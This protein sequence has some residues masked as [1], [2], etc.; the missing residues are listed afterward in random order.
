MDG[1]NPDGGVVAVKQAAPVCR[2][3]EP[4]VAGPVGE[5]P[6]EGG[7]AK[8]FG[9]GCTVEQLGKV[10][11]VGQCTLATFDGEKLFVEAGGRRELFVNGGDAN[12]VECCRMPAQC[13]ADLRDEGVSSLVERGGCIAEQRRQRGEPNPVGPVRLRHRNQNPQPGGSRVRL[14]DARAAGMNGRDPGLA[15]GVAHKADLLAVADEDRYVAGQHRPLLP[16]IGEHCTG[17]QRS[18]DI[19]GNVGSDPAPH[20]V[21]GRKP[22]CRKLAGT[23]PVEIPQP[24]R[25]FA[26][27]AAVLMERGHRIG[28]DFAMAKRRAAVHPIERSQQAGVTATID[29]ELGWAAGCC[30]GV[31][32]G[33]DICSPERIDGLLGITHENKRHPAVKCAAEDF[34]LDRVGVLE[35]IDEDDPV[36]L[37]DASTRHL[38]MNGVG[39]RVTQKYEEVVKV[40]DTGHS[41]TACQLGACRS[42]ECDSLAG[43]RRRVSIVG[44]KARLRVCNRL[45][46]D[47]AGIL[48]REQRAGVSCVAGNVEVVADF[49]E[50]VLD[51]FD[52]QRPRFVLADNTETVKHP[53]AEAVRGRDRCRVEVRHSTQKPPS[54]QSDLGVVGFREIGDERVAAPASCDRVGQRLR[55]HREPGPCALA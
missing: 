16:S 4:V 30:N 29:I 31:D 11:Q 46:C 19:A 15:E 22:A 23:G 53:L 52:Q 10:T 13:C 12:G 2:A 8:P 36:S 1:D 37:L 49:G 21:D 17:G 24:Q 43:R 39:Q 7:Q 41:L 27:D 47:G 44:G 33:R 6:A 14:E 35:F 51:G 3:G 25:R 18:D 9:S 48:G 50:Q 34:P 5:P 32:V 45:P 26:R 40:A 55:S 38:P 20:G 28:D 42:R 54:P